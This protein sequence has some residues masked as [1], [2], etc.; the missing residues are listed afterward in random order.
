MLRHRSEYRKEIMSF[1]NLKKQF[2]TAPAKDRFKQL[3]HVYNIPEGWTNFDYPEY[4]VYR[5][6][7]FPGEEFFSAT[8]MLGKIAAMKGE[9]E[10]LKAWRAR[11][12]D[13]EADR[14]SKEATDRGTAMHQNLQ[15]YVENKEVRNEHMQGYILYQHLKPWCDD[16]I[17]A[18]VASEKAMYSRLLRIAGRTD[19]I[20]ILDGD[21]EAKT[22]QEIIDSG[23]ETLVDFK[24]SKRVKEWSDITSYTRQVSIYAMLFHETTGTQLEMGSIWMGIWNDGEPLAKEFEIIFGNYRETTI[25]EL[26]EYWEW[27]GEP[28]DVYRAKKFFLDGVRVD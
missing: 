13:E 28:L 22:D 5:N 15:D 24:S 14:I 6:P 1:A 3:D 17:T 12:G 10:W 16:R 20:A 23:I 4:R 26:A 11:V 25:D 8:T 21:K 9:D 2:V 19:L 18:V 7:L 27:K